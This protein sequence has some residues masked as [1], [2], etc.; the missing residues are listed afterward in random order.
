MFH[1]TGAV[2]KRYITYML[3]A[4]NDSEFKFS[5]Q[6]VMYLLKRCNEGE[7]NSDSYM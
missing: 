3:L 2:T 5:C 1:L 6:S 7:V 4:C